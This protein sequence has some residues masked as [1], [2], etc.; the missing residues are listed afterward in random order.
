MTQTQHPQ[1]QPSVAPQSPPAPPPPVQQPPAQPG[2]GQQPPGQPPPPTRPGPN[3]WADRGPGASQREQALEEMRQKMH[4]F[5]IHELGP[6][7]Y[8]QRVSE[9]D[10]RRQVD[11]QLH[12]A[13][14]LERLA[15]TGAERQQLVQ[16]VTDDVLGY[17]PI[18]QLLRDGD[19]T[20]VMV[21]GPTHV[22]VE[23]AGRIE[24]STCG[25]S[26]RCTSAASST[27]S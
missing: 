25:S 14:S 24:Q 2:P 18:D 6:L 19:I 5:V 9:A 16:S 21:N 4:Q 15:L 27:R 23:R 26:T 8:D 1:A 3:R 10:L 7:L 20:E 17:G 22:Y 12:R 11:E 13:L